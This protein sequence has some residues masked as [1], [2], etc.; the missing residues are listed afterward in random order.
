MDCGSG[1]HSWSG[2]YG[3][4]KG[5]IEIRQVQHSPAMALNRLFWENMG[6][7][8]QIQKT[9][10]SSKRRSLQILQQKNDSGS[11]DKHRSS[12]AATIVSWTANM[13]LTE[14]G[15]FRSNFFK[16]QVVHTCCTWADRGNKSTSQNENE[17]GQ[18]IMAGNTHSGWFRYFFTWKLITGMA[19]HG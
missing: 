19:K 4:V 2:D 7:H 8:S 16:K 12:H 1:F 10:T 11:D 14:T 17:F 18:D 5:K 9:A 3:N 13:K 15:G 6:K